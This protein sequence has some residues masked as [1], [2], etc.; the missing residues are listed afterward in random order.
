MKLYAS[1]L[2]KPL[3]KREKD[4]NALLTIGWTEQEIAK[5]MR[6][7]RRTVNAYKERANLKLGTQTELKKKT[8]HWHLD[9]RKAFEEWERNYL[10]RLM[11]AAKFNMTKAALLAGLNRTHFYKVHQRNGKR[12][13]PNGK[14]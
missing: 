4:V 12:K 7:D 1:T 6:I 8:R 2:G 10:R 9:Y 11:K 14:K 3:S 5:C 13:F